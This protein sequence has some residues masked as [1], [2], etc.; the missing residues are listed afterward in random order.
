MSTEQ[1]IKN[2][3]SDIE[4]IEQYVSSGVWDAQKDG[5]ISAK[6]LFVDNMLTQLLVGHSWHNEPMTKEEE[7]EIRNLILR[8]GEARKGVLQS[9]AEHVHQLRLPRVVISLNCANLQPV[10]FPLVCRPIRCR[11]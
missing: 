3:Q 2:A 6:I 10:D 11:C 1:N 5:K 8:L 4:E 9:S 7:A